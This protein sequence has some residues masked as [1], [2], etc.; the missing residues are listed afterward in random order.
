MATKRDF[1]EPKWLGY[2]FACGV[3]AGML[4][5]FAMTDQ[6]L[7]HPGLI[8]NVVVPALLICGLNAWVVAHHPGRTTAAALIGFAMAEAV[9]IDSLALLAF[10]YGEPS[11]T[12]LLTGSQRYPIGPL[13]NNNFRSL[14]AGLLAMALQLLVPA[15][16]HAEAEAEAGAP[17][18][19]VIG[20]GDEL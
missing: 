3:P 12:H 18:K 20:V 5:G 15:L 16:R 4:G 13:I 6:V 14:W 2:V 11:V 19:P 10:E 8:P 7:A 9:I 1:G 17:V